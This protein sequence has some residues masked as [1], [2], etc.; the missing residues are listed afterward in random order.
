MHKIFSLYQNSREI[1]FLSHLNQ[2][3]IVTAIAAWKEMQYVSCNTYFMY[4]QTSKSVSVI[5]V[6]VHKI[7]TTMRVPSHVHVV[8]DTNLHPMEGYAKVSQKKIRENSYASLYKNIKTIPKKREYIE[9]DV[10]KY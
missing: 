7:V 5:M 3:V 2:D 4:F 8:T 10:N 9:I 1:D 6:D